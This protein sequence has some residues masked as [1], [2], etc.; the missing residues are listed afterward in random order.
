MSYFGWD[1]KDDYTAASRLFAT[2]DQLKYAG[3]DEDLL[4][5]LND[6]GYTFDQIADYL[7]RHY[8]LPNLI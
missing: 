8:E 1:G 4:I 5:N 7:D 3:I 2:L 6:S